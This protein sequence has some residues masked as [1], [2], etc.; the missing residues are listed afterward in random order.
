MN[1]SIFLKAS[2]VLLFCFQWTLG[3]FAQ[4]K[5]PQQAL[6]QAAQRAL[7]QVAF[8]RTA[9]QLL[10]PQ[11]PTP[12][13]LDTE[14]RLTLDLQSPRLSQSYPLVV[15]AR[16]QIRV[17][18]LGVFTARQKTAEQLKQEL[19]EAARALNRAENL[20][21][22]LFLE[23][24]RPMTVKITGQVINP[25]VYRLPYGT[26]LLQAIRAAGGVGNEGTVFRVE[27]RREQQVL[28]V[29]LMRFYLE[30]ETQQNPTLKP[31]DHIHVPR[32]TQQVLVAGAV[33]QPGIYEVAGTVSVQELLR[34]A[35][36]ALP[37]ADA[38][39]RW[40]ELVPLKLPETLS[41][42]ETLYV[43]TQQLRNQTVLVQG[44]IKQPGPQNWQ[45][46]MRLM[47]VLAAA[48]GAQP[49][50]DLSQ[51]QLS[52]INPETGERQQRILNVAGYLQGQNDALN[53]PLLEAGDVITLPESFFNIR[54]ISEFTTLLLSTLGVVSVVLNFARGTP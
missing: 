30:G 37:D 27:L 21:F 12:Y 49:N 43:P 11:L 54:N 51:V 44:L 50:A 15:N 6:N 39:L 26:A 48:G 47:D 32:L 16:G 9:P 5:I 18:R 8:T 38:P 10:P 33:R 2:L 34:Q 28:P 31:L 20:R 45:R 25:G 46:G 1:V 35:D 22:Q 40:P 29:N 4:A 41:A 17:P 19:Y 53:N 24:P 7:S 14:D 52:R 36:G 23:Q 42:G 13:F 3:A